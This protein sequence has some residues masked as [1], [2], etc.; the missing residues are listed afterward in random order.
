MSRSQ[1]GSC[2]RWWPVQLNWSHELKTTI[3]IQTIQGGRLDTQKYW[4]MQ[5]SLYWSAQICNLIPSLT[6]Q[7]NTIK[8][9]LWTYVFWMSPIEPNSA[10]K[11][12]WPMNRP[13]WVLVILVS[14]SRHF[15]NF[16]SSD[17]LSCS[18]AWNCP[19]GAHIGDDTLQFCPLLHKIH[20][21]YYLMFLLSN[22]LI[23]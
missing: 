1:R 23:Y 21:F 4:G 3:C 10:K 20:N 5:M 7:H 11:R 19:N 14:S 6:S 13:Y 12:F 15:P 22:M 18:Q 8:V 9:I 2:R 16:P 17:L